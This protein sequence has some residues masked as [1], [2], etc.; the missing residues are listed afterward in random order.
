VL[1]KFTPLVDAGA[2]DDL[3]VFHLRSE[4][5]RDP[6]RPRSAQFT[7]LLDT[8]TP[9]V[10]LQSG[11]PATI[12]GALQPTTANHTLSFTSDRT[13]FDADYGGLVAPDRMTVALLADPQSYGVS[14]VTLAGLS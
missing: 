7:H 13:K 6:A 4:T 8:F 2:G 14:G 3:H 1:S 9:T 12:S 5:I 10:T 11:R